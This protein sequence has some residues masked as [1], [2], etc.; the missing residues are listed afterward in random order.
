MSALELFQ[1]NAWSVRAE[2][3][4]GEPWF[5]AA[6]VCAALGITNSR[7]AVAGLDDDEKGVG[8]A[9]TLGGTQ[10]STQVRVTPKGLAELHQRMRGAA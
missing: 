3:R 4:D 2:V 6:D 7:D 10:L 1:T 5:V 8:T 9:D